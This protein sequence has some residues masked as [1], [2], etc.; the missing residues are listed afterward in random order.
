MT[1]LYVWLKFFHLFA[2]AVFLFVHGV[3]RGASIALRA[4]VS[5]ESRRLLSL[6]QRSGII[7]NPSL[8]V[9]IATGVWMG[10]AGHWW[11]QGW[12]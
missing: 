8:L 1:N 12:L 3:S 4:P 11:G 9:V 7:A 5:T 6:S 2:L 10:F